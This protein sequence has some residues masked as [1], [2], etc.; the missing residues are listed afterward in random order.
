MFRAVALSARSCFVR[1]FGSPAAHV[2]AKARSFLVDVAL[3]PVAMV[4]GVR[5]AEL[6]ARG[7]RFAAG[8][9]GVGGPP[10]AH[11]LAIDDGA[12]GVAVAEPPVSDTFAGREVGEGFSFAAVVARLHGSIIAA[13]V[14]ARHTH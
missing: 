12:A 10:L 7:V 13:G 4:A 9:F 2:I 6:A 11:L 14:E 5:F 8:A 3:V 1:V